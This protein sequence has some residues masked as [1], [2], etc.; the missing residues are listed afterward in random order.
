MKWMCN[1]L[2]DSSIVEGYGWLQSKFL[3]LSS[4]QRSFGSADD[5]KRCYVWY[6][7]IIWVVRRTSNWNWKTCFPGIQV[8][9]RALNDRT[10]PSAGRIARLS[11]EP[12]RRAS[13]Q[14][15]P[16][17]S[18][19]RHLVQL[20]LKYFG[21]TSKISQPTMTASMYAVTSK[22]LLLFSS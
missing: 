12:T 13:V 22:I 17:T 19:S 1:F 4:S 15:E 18:T 2:Q 21:H 10:W 6:R 11:P 8:K 14:L 3:P 20:L 7:N 16:E 5:S 9:P